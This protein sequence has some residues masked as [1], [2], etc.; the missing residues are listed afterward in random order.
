MITTT[1]ASTSCSHTATPA[2]IPGWA[3]LPSSLPVVDTID[4]AALLEGRE[5]ES[6]ENLLHSFPVLL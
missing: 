6:M 1:T 5:A 2:A 4:V 3:P